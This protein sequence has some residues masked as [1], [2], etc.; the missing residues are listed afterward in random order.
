MIDATM[1]TGAL[2]RNKSKGCSGTENINIC[3]KNPANLLSVV[4]KEI[5]NILFLRNEYIKV[6]NFLLNFLYL[7][8]LIY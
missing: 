7:I 8:I 2:E 4:P 3:L 5:E 1:S 6:D